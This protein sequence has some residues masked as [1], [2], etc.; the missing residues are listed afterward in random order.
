MALIAEPRRLNPLLRLGIALSER[1][2]GKRMEPARLLAWYP[3]AAVS[4]G[5]LEALVAHQ[6]PSPR[7]LTLVRV[8]TSFTVSCPFC[9]DMNSFGA[10]EAGVDPAELIALQ[11]WTAADLLAVG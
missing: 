5:V 3:R 4:S 9:I 11:Q 10:T 8:T 2:V 7:L 1:M 6:E